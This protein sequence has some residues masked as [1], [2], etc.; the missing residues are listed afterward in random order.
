MYI[1]CIALQDIFLFGMAAVFLLNRI[2]YIVSFHDND[3][4]PN[5]KYKLE[6]LEWELDLEL[7]WGQ[8]LASVAEYR[9]N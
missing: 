2:F 3:Y 8:Y 9:L 5:F 6:L 7:E 4:L 1:V